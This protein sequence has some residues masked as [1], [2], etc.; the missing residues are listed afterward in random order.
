MMIDRVYQTLKMLAN[1]DV[2]G[3]VKPSDFDK[4]L[5]NVINEKYEEYLTTVNQYTNRQ[6]RGLMG[7]DLE[8]LPDR[9]RE[10]IQHYLKSAVLTYESNKFTLPSDLRYIDSI[11]HQNKNLIDLC[12]SAA[13][14]NRISQFKHTAPTLSFPIGLKM[15]NK[16]QVLPATIIANVSINYLRKPFIPKWTYA[17]VNNVELFNPSASGFQDIDMHSSEESDITLRLCGKFGINL[18]ETELEAIA[19]REQ[20]ENYNQK[21]SN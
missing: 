17:V 13:E 5:Y 6:N 14:F 19:N 18:K 7:V 1:T 8:N 11:V 2:Y 15:E 4:A 20:A 9:I 21:L 3:N 16:I 12:G 10:K